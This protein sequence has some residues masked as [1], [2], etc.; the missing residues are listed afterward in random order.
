M[1]RPTTPVEDRIA[2]LCHEE[3][4]HLVWDGMMRNNRPFMHGVNNPARVLLKVDDPR[5]QVRNQCGHP[6]CIDPFHQ[7]VVIER[8]R[9]YDDAPRPTWYDWRLDQEGDFTEQE[10]RDIQEWI[11]MLKS[12][13]VTRK[14]LDEDDLLS[15]PVKAEIR[16]RL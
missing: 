7:K 14:D 5:I 2:R 1:A 12:G 8:P 9:K 10:R 3:G 11:D 4:P 6:R 16:S 13:D 15:D